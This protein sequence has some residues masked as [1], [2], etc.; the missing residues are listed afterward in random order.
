MQQP[1]EQL[2]IPSQPPP[3]PDDPNR[4]VLFAQ[5]NF[6]S[7]NQR[8]GIKL[9]DRRRHM[10]VIGKTGMGKSTLLENMVIQ[11]IQQGRGVAMVDPHGDLVEKVL[12][13]IPD[14]RIDD[15]IYFNPADTHN[16]V[17][18]NILE[19]VEP[20]YRHLVTNG[21][22]GVFK[23][24]WADSWGPRLEYILINTIMSLMEYPGSTLLGVTR[25]L[26]DATYRKRVIR[27]ITDPMVKSFWVNE[28]NNYSEKFR[29]EA[30]API[31]NKVGQF[32]SSALIRNIVGQEKSAMNIREVMDTRKILLMNLSKGRVGEE[33]S[34][35][36]GAMMITKIQLAAMSR[37]DIPEKERKDFYLYVDE[38]QNF[39]T[40]S[41]AGILSE[42]RKYRLNIIMAH[43]YIEQL[44]DEVRAAVFGNIGTMVTFRVGA[45]DA[46]ELEKEYEP[47]FMKEDLVSLPAF[48][49]YLRLMIDGVASEPFSALT[50]PPIQGETGNAQKV[51]EASRKTYS[52]KKHLIE[53]EIEIWAHPNP[54][55]LRKQKKE[56]Q[57]VKDK[58][59][60]EAAAKKAEE[61]PEE[62]VVEDTRVSHSG[63][64]LPPLPPVKPKEAGPSAQKDELQLFRERHVDFIRTVEHHLQ[65]EEQEQ[66]TPEVEQPVSVEPKVASQPAPTVPKPS[67]VI[68]PPKKEQPE[69]P[70]SSPMPKPAVPTPQKPSA[71]RV[72]EKPRQTPVTPSPQQPQQKPQQ[73]SPSQPPR[74]QQPSQPPQSG[75]AGSPEEN[76]RKRKRRRP[77]RK[78]PSDQQQSS[79]Q[80]PRQNPNREQSPAPKP[81]TPTPK[82][83]Q[84]A[85]QPQTPAPKPQTPAAPK[86]VEPQN[87]PQPKNPAP[88]PT[89][90]STPSPRPIQPGDK[91]SFTE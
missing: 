52:G 47:S 56:E 31:Q 44:S 29:N 43:Q 27:R 40:E 39:S 15:V 71:P 20:D 49:V 78:K 60:A 35:L 12:N 85:P 61:E 21:L 81:V 42:A 83:Q 34:A 63:H 57:D 66:K 25:V 19:E 62:E 77:K 22:V 14:N 64:K 68:E 17:A 58:E 26:V 80:P 37:V 41:F 9:D 5:T 36:L 4:A 59:E 90:P 33:N 6:R 86:P 48:Q 2:N 84:A 69:P 79:P 53:G 28:F 13:F 65:Q 18:F 32:L 45:T 11:D 70:K 55:E 74:P 87:K 7:Q 73:A 75:G 24:I 89:A 38:F 54:D 10:Y 82:P 76:A 67:A 8:F 3:N 50:L 30:I 46:E 51:I 72:V 91:V 1:D 88:R 23:K 16:P